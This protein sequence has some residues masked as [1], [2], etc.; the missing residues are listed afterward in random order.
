MKTVCLLRHAKSAWEDGD[1]DDHERPLNARG[2]KA[3]PAMGRWSLAAG[4][5]PDLILCSTAARARETVALAFSDKKV[6]ETVFERG[7]YLATAGTLFRRLQEAP[8]TAATVL[9]VGHNPGL[10]DLALFL[11]REPE[12]PDEARRHKALASKFPTAGFV[13]LRLPAGQWRRLQPARG[14][15]A[16]F[17]SPRDL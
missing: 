13:A 8:E 3:A 10:A 9:M 12:S 15:L 7:L 11:A 4:Y 14:E 2:R 6:G 5:R 16:C 1:L 17:M